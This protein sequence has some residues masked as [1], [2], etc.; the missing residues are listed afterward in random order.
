MLLAHERSHLTVSEQDSEITFALDSPVVSQPYLEHGPILYKVY[1]VGAHHCIVPRP[2]ISTADDGHARWID[3]Q[4]IPKKFADDRKISLLD[5]APPLSR[6][7]VDSYVRSLRMITGL[8]LMGLDLVVC[9]KD[10]RI[11]AVDLN[12]FP[13]YDGND[14]VGSLAH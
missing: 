5:S 6:P 13:G 9:S 10:H 7:F 4:T 8:S 14:N 2:S 1:I 3:S 12:Y 11:Y